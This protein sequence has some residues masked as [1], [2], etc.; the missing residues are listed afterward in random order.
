MGDYFAHWLSFSDRA[1]SELLPRVYY[2]N[3]FLKDSEGKF[4]WPGF[5]DNSRILKWIF[6]RTSGAENGVKTP[7]GVVPAP[8]SLDTS[9]LAINEDQLKQLFQINREEWLK[10]VAGLKEYYKTFDRHLPK[11]IH[12]ELTSLEERLKA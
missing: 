6:E 7:I 5:G 2:V 11:G 9:G 8:G 3:W 12:D 1:K 10:E 4:L